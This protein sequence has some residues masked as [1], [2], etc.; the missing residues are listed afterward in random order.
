MSCINIPPPDV[1]ITS[2]TDA[3]QASNF[4]SALELQTLAYH[5]QLRELQQGLP[6]NPEKNR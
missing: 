1:H 2:Q 4:E 5:R 6:Q 3:S